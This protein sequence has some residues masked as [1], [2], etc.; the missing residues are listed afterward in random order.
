M[1]VAEFLILAILTRKRWVLYATPLVALIAMFMIFEYVDIGPLMTRALTPVP[2]TA[3]L[4]IATTGDPSLGEHAGLLGYDLQYVLHHPLGGGVGSSIHR[5]GP[6]EGTGESAIFDMFGDMGILGGLL[7]L[8]IYALAF[9]IAV[10]AYFRLR[11][12]PPSA[13]FPLVC[14]VA[15]AGLGPITL[16]TDLWGDFATTYLFWWAVGATVTLYLASAPPRLRQKVAFPSTTGS[17]G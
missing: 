15:A 6:S 1:T 12:E 7:Y 9:F 14:A 8:T 10:L 17:E 4:H 3:H 2:H 5:F 13:I 11:R 16:T